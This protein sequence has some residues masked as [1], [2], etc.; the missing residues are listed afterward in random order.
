MLLK[1][2]DLII[3][4]GFVATVVAYSLHAAPVPITPCE[5]DGKNWATIQE[6]CFPNEE[7]KTCANAVPTR[8]GLFGDPTFCNPPAV[9]TK[10]YNGNF[11]CYS[12][13]AVGGQTTTCIRPQAPGGGDMTR[14]C[15]DLQPCEPRDIGQIFSNWVCLPVGNPTTQKEKIWTNVGCKAANAP[16]GG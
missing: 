13:E 9:Y 1:K 4:T 16:G 6:G 11:H 10:R 3:A 12:S 14:D 15:L 8:T 2:S 7:L 5:A